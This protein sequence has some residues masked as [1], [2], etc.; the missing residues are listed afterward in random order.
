M[1]IKTKSRIREIY[2]PRKFVH[3]L[4]IMV[5]YWLAQILAS[6]KSTNVTTQ[7]TENDYAY[8]LFVL[9]HVIVD[10]HTSILLQKS[11]FFTIKVQIIRLILVVQNL[12][13]WIMIEHYLM[14]IANSGENIF[15]KCL[16][17]RSGHRVLSAIGAELDICQGVI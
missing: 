8:I 13:K 1:K 14:Y 4:H 5:S 15:E 11:M 6:R 10:L 12:Q 7:Q 3:K 17:T 2:V 9:V 16:A